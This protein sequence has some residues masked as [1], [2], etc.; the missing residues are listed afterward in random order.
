MGVVQ[1]P[2]DARTS[3]VPTNG[4]VHVTDV[5]VN[6]APMTSAPSELPGVASRATRSAALDTRQGIPISNQPNKFAA[7]TRKIVASPRLTHGSAANRLR[8][9][10]PKTA[11]SARPRIVKVPT[12][13]RANNNARRSPRGLFRSGVEKY[14]MVTGTMGN[15]HGV[16]SER[17]PVLAASQKKPT[18]TF[19]RLFGGPRPACPFA[20]EGR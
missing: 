6:V 1:D 16:R 11:A 10:A 9:A 8:P 20:G 15:T 12:I 19:D 17:S 3:S 13:P 5:S 7:K 18:L 2:C 4:A 14:A